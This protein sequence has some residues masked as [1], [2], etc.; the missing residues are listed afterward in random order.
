MLCDLIADMVTDRLA[1]DMNR[2]MRNAERCLEAATR[3]QAAIERL[4]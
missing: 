4:R 1:E 2:M 3:L